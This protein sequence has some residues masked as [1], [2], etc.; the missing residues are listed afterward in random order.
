M[1]KKVVSFLQ[2]LRLLRCCLLRVLFLYKINVLFCQTSAK[3]DKPKN[4]EPHF[5]CIKK[6]IP[7]RERELWGVFRAA[8]VATAANDFQS[9]SI[10]QVN[11]SK[12][13]QLQLQQS[14]SLSL[15]LHK[16]NLNVA[17]VQIFSQSVS[18]KNFFK[19]F[20][21]EFSVFRF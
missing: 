19:I 6:F 14:L 17:R 3:F 15:F 21:K 8:A 13:V 1:K 18:C 9:I 20:V 10:K 7:E 4:F 16:S 12:Q 5:F 11:N 2:F